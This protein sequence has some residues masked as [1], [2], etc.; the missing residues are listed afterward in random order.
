MYFSGYRL[1]IKF[2]FHKMIAY[3]LQLIFRLIYLVQSTVF[4]NNT[5][6]ND[7]TVDDDLHNYVVTLF[8]MQANY[9]LE[10]TDSEQTKP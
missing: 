10:K 4:M 9:D 6:N 7:F 1:G 3:P 8:Q 5:S 2:P